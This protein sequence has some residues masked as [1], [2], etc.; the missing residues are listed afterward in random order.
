MLDQGPVARPRDGDAVVAALS[1]AAEAL[2]RTAGDPGRVAILRPPGAGRRPVDVR[3]EEYA[4]RGRRFLRQTRKASLRYAREMFARAA[5]ADPGYALA[6]AGEAE[7]IALVKM[8]YATDG[9]DLGAADRASARAVELDPALAEAHTARG[10][11]LFQLGRREEARRELERAAALDPSL[12]EA[13]YYAGRVAFQEGRTEDAARLFREASR[14]REHH[15]AA[16]FAAQAVEALGRGDEA[17]AAYAAA[18]AVLERH[19]DLN[20]DDPRAATMRALAL[21]RTGRRD[22]GLRWAREALAMDPLDAGVRYNVACI[23]AVEGAKDE[24]LALLADALRAGFG[25]REWFLR[26]PDLASL[27]GDPRFEALLAG[28]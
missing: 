15:A 7:A 24:A 20:P 12:A 8:Y 13:R 17:R 3:A 4:Q 25:N 6:H 21:C 5:A 22:E 9:A 2:E 27:R 11:T 16:F 26:D 23:H 28:V 14:A 10:I 19:M 18:L 1:P